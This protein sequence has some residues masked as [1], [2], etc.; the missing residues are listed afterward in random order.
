MPPQPDEPHAP[1][2]P[3]EPPKPAARKAAP[4]PVPR[5]VGPNEALVSAAP[6]EPPLTR[7]NAMDR[8]LFA[9]ASAFG[10]DTTQVGGWIGQIQD[11]KKNEKKGR[12]KVVWPDGQL[13]TTW[14]HLVSSFRPI[15]CPID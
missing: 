3:D 8:W 1:P 11:I 14:D 12:T 2:Q 5:E 7:D 10:G 6:A 13:W 4:K 9:P 15:D